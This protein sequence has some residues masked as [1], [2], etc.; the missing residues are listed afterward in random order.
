MTKVKL[1]KISKNENALRDNEIE[2]EASKLPKVGESF[3]MT[4]PPRD[5]PRGDR[6][7][8]T[9]EVREIVEQTDRAVTF[10]TLNSTYRVEISRENP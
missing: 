4:A 9:S 6:W 5:I 3:H 7:V 2:G 10:H 1:I 8:T